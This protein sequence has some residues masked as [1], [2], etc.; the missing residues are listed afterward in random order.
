MYEHRFIEADGVEILIGQ[1]D[2]FKNVAKYQRQA[3]WAML[4]LAATDDISR[5]IV[6]QGG[7]TAVLSAMF[8]HKYVLCEVLRYIRD[9]CSPFDCLLYSVYVF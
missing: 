6:N 7:G 5:L 8:T 1:M 4:T 2:L 3:L 9:S